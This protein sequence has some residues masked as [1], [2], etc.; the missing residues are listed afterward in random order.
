M[1]RY[2]LRDRPAKRRENRRRTCH[3]SAV[4]TTTQNKASAKSTPAT[5]VSGCSSE[6]NANQANTA[7]AATEGAF[8]MTAAA[9]IHPG[10]ASEAALRIRCS[11]CRLTIARRIRGS[12]GS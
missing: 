7:A 9:Q 11:A 3:A 12:A 10:R 8:M 1:V 4:A 6:V 2:A 5:A